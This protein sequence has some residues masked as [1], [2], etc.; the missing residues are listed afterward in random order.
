[1]LHLVL[2]P[3]RLLPVPDPVL[4]RCAISARVEQFNVGRY[5]EG[6]W[7]AY[8]SWCLGVLGKI[9]EGLLYRLLSAV[10]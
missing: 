6:L 7:L 8:A 10:L 5:N 3:E 9:M 4:Y 1:M 2:L